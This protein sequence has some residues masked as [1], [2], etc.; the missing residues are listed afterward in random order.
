MKQIMVLVF[1]IICTTYKVQ[2]KSLFTRRILSIFMLLLSITSYAQVTSNFYGNT[3]IQ[4]KGEAKEWSGTG[5]A[6]NNGYM[7]TNYHVVED[8]KSIKVQGISK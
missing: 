5:F 6:L 7:A 1:A 3:K 4:S 2:G 8:A